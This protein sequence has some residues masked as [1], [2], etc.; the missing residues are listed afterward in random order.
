MIKSDVH[1]IGCGLSALVAAIGIKR[2]EPQRMVV[3]HRKQT[4]INRATDPSLHV[5]PLP[6]LKQLSARTGINYAELAGLKQLHSVRLS[7]LTQKR[8]LETRDFDCGPVNVHVVYRGSFSDRLSLDSALFKQAEAERVVFAEEEIDLDSP[9]RGQIIIA[10]GLSPEM[11][12]RLGIP[13]KEVRGYYFREWGG[14]KE[15]SAWE[16]HAPQ[17]SHDYCYGAEMAGLKFGAMLDTLGN[18]TGCFREFIK[19]FEDELGE[20]HV[21][22]ESPRAFVPNSKVPYFYVDDLRAGRLILAGTISP[23]MMD[24][25]FYFGIL[26]AIMSGTVAAKAVV[27]G[28]DAAQQDF[29]EITANFKRAAFF[30]RLLDKIP[31]FLLEEAYDLMVHRKIRGATIFNHVQSI[32]TIH[33]GIGLIEGLPGLTGYISQNLHLLQ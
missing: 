13:A 22:V 10:T 31:P 32:P 17:L 12:I 24:P 14:S 8:G 29:L 9:P 3:I 28:F 20:H 15:V 6:D 4:E 19:A 5:T 23:G 25:V 2:R 11:F 27:E 30:R 16:F 21:W 1:I 18:R 7:F 26:G 33:R